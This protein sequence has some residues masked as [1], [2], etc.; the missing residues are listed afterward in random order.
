MNGRDAYPGGVGKTVFPDGLLCREVKD[1]PGRDSQSI[2]KDESE[3]EQQKGL[4]CLALQCKP[5]E[6]LTLER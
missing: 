3:K 2:E 5:E 4:L 6:W 1:S